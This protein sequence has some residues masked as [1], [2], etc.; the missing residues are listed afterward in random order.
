MAGHHHRR[1][2]RPTRVLEAVGLAALGSAAGWIAYSRLGI[3][4]RVRLPPALPGAFE[5]LAA[6]RAGTIALYGATEAEGPPLLLIH[7]INAAASAYEMRPL[8]CH[9]GRARPVYALDLPGFG[10]S[11][12]SP[13]RYTPRLMVDAI[14]AVAAEVRR[15]HGGARLDAVA[16]SLSSAY[17]A[18]AALE[19]AADYRSLGLI[20]PT[21]FD[22]RLSGR[23]PRGGHRGNDLVLR[24]LEVPIWRRALFDA[25][26]SRPSIRFFLSK[27]FGSSRIDED[28]LDYDDR[29]AHQPGAEYAPLRFLSGYLFPTDATTLYEALELPVWMIHGTR[30]DFVDFRDAPRFA[31]RPN[32]TVSALP[33][34]ALPQFEDL[35]AVTARYDAFLADRVET[36]RRDRGNAA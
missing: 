5:H 16:L 32:W 12:R 25:L 21:G 36:A 26:V 28:L 8:F 27:T 17:L 19:R 24:G 9:Y 7:S 10:H 31:G 35:E 14:H 2:P 11:E 22:A 15:R 34:G 20:S 33:T 4:H 30:G 23:G 13:R 18:R 1:A 6:G 29:S 3:D